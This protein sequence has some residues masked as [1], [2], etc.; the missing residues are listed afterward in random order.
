MSAPALGRCPASRRSSECTGSSS[1]KYSSNDDGETPEIRASP[2]RATRYIGRQSR[3]RGF[4]SK[5]TSRWRSS[6]TQTYR[7]HR[8]GWA[9]KC[10][11]RRA[12]RPPKLSAIRLTPRGAASDGLGLR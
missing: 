5:S 4:T 7:T 3:N 9:E 10:R 8:S 6:R 1:A 12:K 11:I 2:A